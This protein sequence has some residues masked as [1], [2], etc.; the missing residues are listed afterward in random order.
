MTSISFIIQNSLF[1]VIS[2]LS[3]II[4]NPAGSAQ[5]TGISW[6]TQ[7]SAV[8]PPLSGDVDRTGTLFSRCGGW[9]HHKQTL[10]WVI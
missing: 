10:L 8:K 7:Q 3:E 6:T 9:A 4:G 1:Y 5:C 2:L